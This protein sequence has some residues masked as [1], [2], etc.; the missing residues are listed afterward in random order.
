MPNTE[1]KV[2][3][4]ETGS[5]LAVRETGEICVRGPQVRERERQRDFRFCCFSY[6]NLALLIYVTDVVATS[7]RL[8]H[9][10]NLVHSADRSCG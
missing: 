10:I 4:A 7:C 3:H 2:V 5:S 1:M 9:R 6:L 8:T